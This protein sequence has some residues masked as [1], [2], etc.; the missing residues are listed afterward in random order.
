VAGFHLVG[1]TYL[2]SVLQVAVGGL[3]AGAVYLLYSRLVRLPELP[4]A[5]GL[6][7]QALLRG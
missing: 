4:R 1:S 3:A 6:V 5:I 7:R 2:S